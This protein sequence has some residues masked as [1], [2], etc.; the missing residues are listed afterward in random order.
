MTMLDDPAPQAEA[1]AQH[2]ARDA[3]GDFDRAL[4]RRS[5]SKAGLLM[6]SATSLDERPPVGPRSS[7][8]AGRL[9]I[10]VSI[11]GCSGA[12]TRANEAAWTNEAPSANAVRSAN[13]VT[14]ANAATSVDEVTS[15]NE[16][17]LRPVAR[18]SAAK[19]SAV[20]AANSASKK[21][22][23]LPVGDLFESGPKC[24]AACQ[25]LCER[26]CKRMCAIMCSEW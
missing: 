6:E 15:P 17:T 7:F 18:A 21:S 14:S 23:D 11:C 26:D 10:C 24:E 13:A 16:V 3:T 25:G 20:P 22:D 5:A 12:P 1:F 19:A 2:L 9:V 4:S 8:N